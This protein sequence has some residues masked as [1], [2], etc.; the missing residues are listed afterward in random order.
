[1]AIREVSNVVEGARILSGTGDPLLVTWNTD[2]GAFKFEVYE[3]TGRQFLELRKF[4]REQEFDNIENEELAFLCVTD[5]QRL[6]VM[7]TFT[8]VM[9]EASEGK[10][11]TQEVFDLIRRERDMTLMREI[12][13][14][15]HRAMLLE[16]VFQELYVLQNDAVAAVRDMTGEKK[17]YNLT[18]KALDKLQEYLEE[19]KQ[20]DAEE[21]EESPGE[22]ETTPT[23]SEPQ[24]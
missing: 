5:E 18:M 9:A 20:K 16:D 4:F 8:Y 1:M 24:S 17:E 15:F 3:G 23:G 2:R 22:T 10:L 13:C 11:T 7:L 19:Q 14:F 6:C 12:H 21:G